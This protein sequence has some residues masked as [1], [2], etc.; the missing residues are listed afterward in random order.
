MRFL[1]LGPSGMRGAVGSALTGQLAI[2]YASA[3][4]TWLDGGTVGVAIDT[5]TS[6]P[7]F[8]SACF[9]GLLATGCNVIDFG[10]CPA[11]VLHFAVKKLGLDGG[12]LIGAGHHQGG[13]NAIVPFSRRGAC[14]SPLQTQEMLDIYHGG[15]FRSARWNR[16]GSILPAPETIPGD[17]VEDLAKLVNVRE[18]AVHRFRVVTDFCNGS[19]SLLKQRIAD[20]FG[21]DMVPINDLLSGSLPHDPEPR[22]RSS[23]Q[24]KSI[25]KPLRADAG[26]V[27]S[28]DVGRAAIVTDTGET[29]SEEYTVSIAAD[30][31]LSKLPRGAKVATNWC[32]TKTLDLIVAK[33]GGTICKGPTG[34]AY[35]LELMRE[36]N[37]ALGGDG[38]GGVAVAASGTAGFDGFA[39]MLLM[40]ETM[41]LRNR[42]SSEIAGELPR[43]HITKM[44]LPCRSFKAYS[45]LRALR[46]LFPEAAVTEEDGLRFDWPDG[47]IH[48]RMSMTE[49]ILRM[50]SEWK[51]PGD[52]VGK[53]MHIRA[54][55]ERMIAE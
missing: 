45:V 30:N 15:V 24:V 5:R 34:E 54:A 41:A 31:V 53:I 23:A 44:S 37:A 16:T 21:L 10:I 27:F 8:K 12:M 20:R 55:V 48:V 28:S 19:G 7:M 9:A 14:L 33:H 38:S 47:W 6:S 32:S 11:P 29:L 49:P 40:L 50:I 46:A 26:F 42:R 4:G 39:A 35:T 52:G 43:W 51:N 13:W 25:M 18:L 3:F 2:K 36:Q 17:Y 1:R 22:P